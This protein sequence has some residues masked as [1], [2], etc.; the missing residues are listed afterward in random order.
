[1]TASHLVACPGCARHVRASEPACPFCSAAL[2]EGLRESVPREGPSVRLSRA[3]LVAFGVG[4]LTVAAAG[5]SSNTTTNTVIP[6][7]VPPHVDAASEQDDA[8][9]KDTGPRH[10]AGRQDVNVAVPYGVPVYGAPPPVDAGSPHDAEGTK[11]SGRQDAVMGEPPYGVP[12]QTDA[13]N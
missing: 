3:A 7:G 11:D 8:G 4:S 13:S 10:D 2:P 9:A 1:M 12:P 5:C 6:Y